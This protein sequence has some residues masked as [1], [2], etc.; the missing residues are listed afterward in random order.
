MNGPSNYTSVANFQ[1]VIAQEEENDF[2]D[3]DQ[4]EEI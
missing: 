4:G 1:S 2:F 3:A